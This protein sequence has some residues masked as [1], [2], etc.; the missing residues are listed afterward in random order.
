MVRVREVG[1]NDDVKDKEVITTLG[2][3]QWRK[4]MY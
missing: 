4:N 3:G 2:R 1:G